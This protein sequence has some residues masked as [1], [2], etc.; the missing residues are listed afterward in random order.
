MDVIEYREYCLSLPFTEECTPFDETT[1]VFKVAGKMFAYADM[2][3]FQ[4]I[5]MK[6]EP[7]KALELRENYPDEVLPA[8]H[9]NKK[10]WNMV[11]TDGDLP[12][13]LIKEWIRD[14][15]LLVVE[16]LPRVKRWEIM[17]ELPDL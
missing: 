15:Y 10:H 12:D 11:R 6:C 7:N 13:R 9:S 16:K 1:L 2:E 3:E 14:S 8:Y 4:W 17:D 5:A